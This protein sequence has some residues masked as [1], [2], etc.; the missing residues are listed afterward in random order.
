MAETSASRTAQTGMV[1]GL[2][3]DRESAERAYGSM[4]ERGYAQEDVNLVMSEKHEKNISQSTI[5]KLNSA[6]RRLK[7]L[8]LVR[9]SV[10]QWEQR[11]PQS[12]Q[13]EPR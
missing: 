10:E 12:Q 2:F 7:A 11:W 13:S 1:T 6:I 3:P 8:G 5:G 4:I 9:R